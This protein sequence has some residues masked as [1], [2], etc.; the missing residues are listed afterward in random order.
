MSMA[1]GLEARAPLTDHRLLEFMAG[2]PPAIDSHADKRLL[3]ESMRGMLPNWLLRQPKRGFNPPLARWL[4]N[5]LRVML[6][7]WLSP[8]QVRRRGLFRVEAVEALKRA[9]LSGRRDLGH[10]LWAL[11]VLERWMQFAV[12]GESAELE[13]LQ[14]GASRP[15]ETLAQA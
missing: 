3:K 12:D 2:I 1:H 10:Q 9:H 13:P 6:E 5:E 8:E 4:K 14:T 7:R 11:M 15:Q